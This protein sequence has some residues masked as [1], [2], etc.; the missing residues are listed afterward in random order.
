MC[1]GCAV[2]AYRHKYTNA[3]GDDDGANNP[4]CMS[5]ESDGESTLVEYEDCELDQR[6][7]NSL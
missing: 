5:E 3:V 2:A 1:D 7:G 4:Y 6:S